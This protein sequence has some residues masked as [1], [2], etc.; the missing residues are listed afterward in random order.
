MT[1]TAPLF[2]LA[3]VASCGL[4]AVALARPPRNV[5]RW[6]FALGMAGFAIEALA[7]FALVTWSEKSA[8]HLALLK[9]TLMAGLL[10][11]IPW[12]CFVATLARPRDARLSRR[13]WLGLGAGTVVAVGSA[14]AVAL[15]PTFE[16]ADFAG[17]FYA[18]R[19]QWEG[20]IAVLVQMLATVGFLV[21]C[22]AA[23]RTAKRETR[24]RIKFLVLG[25]GGVLLVR[26]YFL[27]QVV[28]FNVVMANYLVAG[29][30]TLL[31]GDM[32]IAAALI[33]DRLAVELTVSRQVLYRSVV[34][35]TLGIYLLAVGVLGWLLN[36]LGIA[37]ELFLGSVVVF[38]SAVGL[39]SVLL[40]EKVRWWFKGFVARHFY[41]TKYDYR[42]QWGNFTKRLSSLVTLDE[43]A[44]ELLAAVA[45]TVGATVGVLYL[46]DEADNR[47]RAACAIG[48]GCPR[49]PVSSDQ[50]LVVSLTTVQKPLIVE[51]ADV[52]QWM[53]PSIASVFT[54]GSTIVPIRWS[55]NL[56]GFLMI[57][58]E[59]TGIPYT[60]E[61]LEFLET[62]TEQAAG[63]IITARLSERLVQS[64]EFEAFH[65]L[66]SFVIHDLKNSI[67][68]LAMLSDNAL[69]NFADPEF[70]RDTIKTVSKTVER[71]KALLTR[72][73][74]APDSDALR[75]EP[76]D[77]AT[78]ALE[79]ARPV[80][81]N[82]RISLVKDL[83]PLPISADADAL[84]KVIQ[85]LITKAM[86][87]IEGQGTV[88][89][90]T[91]ER[92]GWAVLSVSDTGCGM[93]DEFIRRSLFAPFRSTKKGGW[94]IGL[95]Q[96]KGIVEAHG[97]RIEVSS[98][99]GAGTSFTIKLPFGNRGR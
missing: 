4:G 26:F 13:L 88:R 31:V 96:T 17:A 28:L 75:L 70:Q 49:E 34:A 5:L 8:H 3:A 38:V 90:R 44:P 53:E 77:L 23:L 69:Q 94:G 81:K 71:M 51:S 25:L 37:E 54:E 22:E 45:E 50:S 84:L 18:A 10:L 30:A 95:Y 91:F 39:A 66:T 87:S 73:A 9:A 46:R 42:D 65:R 2:I 61:D 92:D 11:L 21:G 29:A 80:V 52:S 24:Q 83:A 76:L 79:A 72:L 43:L 27:S 98:R 7:A 14:V 40:S 55:G 32:V 6:S 15:L 12:G 74:A 97:G 64:H 93:S 78:L 68:A 86:Q 33:R 35:G 89:L 56:T 62:V 1:A 16:V 41:R 67:S 19:I 59:R 85:N 48:T 47:Y 36:H 20:R 99:E 82:E 57:G 58:P 63:A 60:M